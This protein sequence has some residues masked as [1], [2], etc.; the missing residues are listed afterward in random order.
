MTKIKVTIFEGIDGSG[1][2]TLAKAFAKENN[3]VYISFPTQR[4]PEFDN[5]SK[6]AQ[7]FID[8]MSVEL[9]KYAQKEWRND[10]DHVEHIVLD[11]SFISTAVYQGNVFDKDCKL[12]N[13]ILFHG[14]DMLE[15]DFEVV[16]VIIPDT[17]PLEAAKRIQ[18][19]KAGEDEL[20]KI[21]DLDELVARLEKYHTAFEHVLRMIKE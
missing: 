20:D 14:I 16:D 11:R 21:E 5:A 19:R 17:T 15:Q 7:W 12:T 9:G 10:L 8:D 3:A 2:T 1:K 4:P 6:A 18:S 13:S